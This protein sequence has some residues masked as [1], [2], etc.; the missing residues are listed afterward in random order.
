MAL[1]TTLNDIVDMVRDEARLSSNTSRGSDHRANIVRLIRRHYLTLADGYDW[2]HL[3]LRF[4]DSK[5][6]MVAGQRFYDFPANL[7][8]DR[9]VEV[10][11]KH[12]AVWNPLDYGIGLNEYSARDSELDERT[13]PVS[14]WD[15]YGHAQ[16]EVW[17]IP[18]SA[19]GAVC[20][21]GQKKVEPLSADDSRADLDD[22]L[23]AL[24]ASAE[25]LAGNKQMEAAQAKSDAARARLQ[26]LKAG[27]SD[28]SRVCIGRGPAQAP[29]HRPRSIDY[30]R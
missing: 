4:G 9:I 23:I 26:Q 13:D 20:F 15:Y 8:T 6:E 17:P 19:S 5:K 1:R 24:F 25:I 27:K 10:H 18:A 3:S 22:E 29:S 7:N 21:T 12:G 30:V 2:Q 14:K 16:F 11:H 28:K